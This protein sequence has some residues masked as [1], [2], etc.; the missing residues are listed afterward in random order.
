MHRTYRA[1]VIAG[2]D[3]EALNEEISRGK[4]KEG[5]ENNEVS[6]KKRVTDFSV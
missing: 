2:K 6:N 5:E 1:S 3:I 4:K